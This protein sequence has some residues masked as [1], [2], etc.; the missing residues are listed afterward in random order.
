MEFRDWDD[1]PEFMRNDEVKKYY[2]T[3]SEKRFSLEV[4]RF[5]DV[6][7]S[8][9]L[10][11]VLS[12]VFAVI[13]V[14]I[15]L[16]SK[17]PVYYKQERITQYGRRFHIFKFRTM[18]ADADKKGSLITV[19]HDARITNVGKKI[20]K[21]RLDEIP[22]IFNI[23]AGD[24]SFVGT[25]PEVSK[26]VDAYS[27]EMK[28]TLLLPAGVTSEASIEY[29]D[30]DKLLKEAEDLDAV[31]VDQ[32]LPEKM[33]WNLKAIKTYSMLYELKILIRTA[34]AVFR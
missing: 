32:I 28:A 24:M 12:P 19:Q 16:D 31:Y 21:Y 1:V 22:Q 33:K 27:D 13:T 11:F 15:K 17:G 34:W 3:L 2:K 5:F 18:I 6:V 4:K 23:L 25:R 30:E 10:L 8:V 14:W 29:K 9:F 20:R 7:M 26:Y